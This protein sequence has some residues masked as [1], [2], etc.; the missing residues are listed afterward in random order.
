MSR[1]NPVARTAEDVWRLLGELTEAQKRTEEAQNRAADERK[2]MAAEVAEAQKRTEEAQKRAIDERKKM[3]AKVA[4]EMAKQKK[5][6]DLLYKRVA[7][8]MKSLSEDLHKSGKRLQKSIDK[9]NGNFNNKWGKFVENLVRSDLSR[10]LKKINIVTH[11]CTQ[12]TYV[13]DD[14]GQIV[15]ECDVSAINGRQAVGVEVKTT[16]QEEDVDKFVDVLDKYADR[17]F[18][19][20][21]EV[22]GAMAFMVADQDVQKYAIKKGMILIQSPKTEVGISSLVTPIDFKP[23]LFFKPST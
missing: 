6:N 10:L 1:E 20:D 7:L 3:A 11:R 14:E 19:K 17:L 4:A 5:E 18:G 8:R 13:E 23:R 12:R 2:R 9:T 16:L 21:K 15:A 22:Y